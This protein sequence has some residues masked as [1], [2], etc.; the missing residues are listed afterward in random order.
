[1]R[2][3]TLLQLYNKSLSTSTLDLLKILAAGRISL[4]YKMLKLEYRK[5]NKDFKPY[6]MQKILLLLPPQQ[7]S[8]IL[9]HLIKS[10]DQRFRQIYNNAMML[11]SHTSAPTSTLYKDIRQNIKLKEIS[12]VSRPQRLKKMEFQS[13]P[14]LIK[15]FLT[16][17]LHPHILPGTILKSSFGRPLSLDL[18]LIVKISSII[19]TMNLTLKMP[20]LVSNGATAPLCLLMSPYL[21]SISA[22]DASILPLLILIGTQLTNLMS[23]IQKIVSSYLHKILWRPRYGSTTKNAASHTYSTQNCVLIQMK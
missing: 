14:V 10:I 17:Q 4:C 8:A 12:I 19:Q 7:V 18:A 11:K 21:K 6:K 9:S 2:K 13:N 5:D 20:N 1:M 15:L 23:M 16:Y 3:M 22:L